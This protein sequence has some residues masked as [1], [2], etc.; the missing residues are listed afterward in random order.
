[1][2]PSGRKFLRD[3]WCGLLAVALALLLM[4]CQA[5]ITAGD[6][7]F[8]SQPIAEFGQHDDHDHSS[9]HPDEIQVLLAN[10]HFVV[11]E[12]RVA[13][14]IIQ[15]GRSVKG[16]RMNARF[17][18]L[19]SSPRLTDE[20]EATYYGENLGGAGIYA[21]RTAFDQAGRWG[22][23]AIVW[24]E[25]AEPQTVRIGFEVLA[26]DP[27]PAIGTLAPLTHSKTLKK[28]GN[29]REEI[30]SAVDDD[31]AFHELSIAE[32]VSNGKPTVI[33][34]A[35]PGFCTTRTCGPSLEV[36]QA[37]QAKY[38][39]QANFIHVEIYEDFQTFQV[40]E[41]VQEWRLTTEPW[42]FF[43]DREGKIAEKIE[44]GITL[45][46]VEPLL[47]KVFDN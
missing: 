39:M 9:N 18:N 1:M 45:A 37:L 34:F 42:V 41:A 12:S 6:Q 47:R 15:N 8:E 30:C 40:A 27:T 20:G 4:G 29:D 13:F 33:L 24:M 25:G 17:F 38:E 19:N 46:E 11:G 43:I 31:R 44:G 14:G 36:V 28:S 32:A 35:T 16:V 22:V 10:S 5:N 21:L 26:K 3:L 2:S 7:G 23:E